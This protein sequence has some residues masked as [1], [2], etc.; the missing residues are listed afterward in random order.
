MFCCNCCREVSSPHHCPQYV[1]P[2]ELLER[3]EAPI[4]I[5]HINHAEARAESFSSVSLRVAI[6]EKKS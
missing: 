3:V 1:Q 5:K 2:S 4:S 6:P